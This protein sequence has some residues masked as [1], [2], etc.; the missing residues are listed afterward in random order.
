RP[1]FCGPPMACMLSADSKVLL[2]GA[3]SSSGALSPTGP[4][5]AGS[6]S[7]SG[8][9]AGGKAQRE[10]YA[11]IGPNAGPQVWAFACECTTTSR[12]IKVSAPTKSFRCARYIH[13][14]KPLV[15]RMSYIGLS[16]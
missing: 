5:I 10:Q 4:G 9:Y 7:T 6:G 15:V 13:A 8:S 3:P 1:P 11:P 16:P 12:H 2:Y 14:I